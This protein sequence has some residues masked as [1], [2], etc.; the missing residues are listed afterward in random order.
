MH[1][2]ECWGCFF[3]IAGQEGLQRGQGTLGSIG[4]NEAEAYAGSEQA[5]RENMPADSNRLG[6]PEPCGAA[7][8]PL[9]GG[10][11]AGNRAR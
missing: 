4:P 11:L 2:I 1:L 8:E 7:H 3:G 6:Q 9:N 5:H 10:E